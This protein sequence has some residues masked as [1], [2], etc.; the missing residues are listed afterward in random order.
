MADD[1]SI[2]AALRMKLLAHS[3]QSPTGCL[4]WTGPTIGWGYGSLKLR[5]KNYTTHRAAWLAYRGPIPA[6]AWVLHRCDNPPCINPEHLFLGDAKANTADM[7]AKGRYGRPR[8]VGEDQ[9]NHKLTWAQVREIRQR[10][11]DGERQTD[12]AE[13]YGVN[14]GGISSVVLYKTWNDADVDSKAIPRH[15]PIGQDH[16][17]AKLTMDIARLI[18]AACAAGDRQEA[19]SL[20]FGVS[21]SLVSL[22]WLNKRWV[23]T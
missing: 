7:H 10:Y 4:E 2:I 13:A 16:H 15:Y 17:N 18:R 23:E 12:L 19:V 3:A 8:T 20:R 6:G 11:A 9:W 14:Q 1:D 22:I 21:Q 5:G